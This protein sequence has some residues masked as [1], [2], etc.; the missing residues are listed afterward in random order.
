M[1]SA[2]SVMALALALAGCGGEDAPAPPPVGGGATPTPTPSNCTIEFQN[3][4]C[5]PGVLITP[6]SNPP[7][8]DP[9]ALPGHATALAWESTEYKQN[10][11]L[12]QIGASLAYSRGAFGQGVTIA[13]IDVGN[14]TNHPEVFKRVSSSST[15]IYDERGDIVEGD[16]RWAHGLQCATLAMGTRNGVGAHGVAIGAELLYIRADAGFGFPSLDDFPL[17]TNKDLAES[18][19]YAVANG[20]S[21]ISLSLGVRE[22]P[23]NLLFDAIRRAT[24]AG[25]VVVTALGNYFDGRAD[26]QKNIVLLPAA[27][28]A[29]PAFQGRMV[30]AGASNQGGEI[31]F[32]SPRAGAGGQ[33][34]FLLAPGANMLVPGGGGARSTILAPGN[35]TS[36]L[37]DS[38]TSFAAP[39][40]AGAIAVVMSGRNVSAAEALQLLY[41]NAVDVGPAGTDATN[42]RGRIDLRPIFI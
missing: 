2:T 8:A 20:A 40:I 5:Q 34:A 22:D 19:D 17:H 6:V 15:S 32:F 23:G 25:V 18:I 26:A 13:V 4:T 38:G 16:N 28:G 31:A 27:F 14:Q 7:P 33:D 11:G 30:L 10:Y 39:H 36:F 35:T 42:G 1:K 41:E 37:R 29:D 24:D 12:E 9:P 21:V 3:Q